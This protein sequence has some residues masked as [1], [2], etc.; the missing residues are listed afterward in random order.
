LSKDTRIVLHRISCSSSNS[1]RS[2]V[3]VTSRQSLNK[4]ANVTQSITKTVEVSLIDIHG[5]FL[6]I[7]NYTKANIHAT[8][9]VLRVAALVNRNRQMVIDVFGIAHRSSLFAGI[10]SNRG[11]SNGSGSFVSSSFRH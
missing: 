4:E 5:M 8:H 10:E 7:N 3:I 11:R 1:D 9:V 2:S 6:V